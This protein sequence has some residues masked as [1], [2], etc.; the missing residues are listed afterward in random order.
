MKIKLLVLSY[1]PNH[2]DPLAALAARSGAIPEDHEIQSLTL[3]GSDKNKFSEEG[4]WFLL[5][6]WPQML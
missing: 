2:R 4:C 5:E 6:E 1:D 3:V